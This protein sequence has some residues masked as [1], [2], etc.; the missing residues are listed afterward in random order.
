MSKI[1]QKVVYGLKHWVMK[2][3][4]GARLA[5]LPYAYLTKHCSMKIYWGVDV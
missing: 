1:E 5:M 2:T 3:C 4:L